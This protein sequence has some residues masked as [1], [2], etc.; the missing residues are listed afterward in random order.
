MGHVDPC[1]IKRMKSKEKMSKLVIKRQNKMQC[2][3]YM[4]EMKVYNCREKLSQ[5]ESVSE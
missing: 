3:K 5:G 2:W 4:N 1:V